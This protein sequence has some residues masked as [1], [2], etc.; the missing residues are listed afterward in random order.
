MKKNWFEK[1][2]LILGLSKSGIAAAKY[3][4]DKCANVYI[5]ESREERPEDKDLIEELKAL[6]IQVEMGGHSDEFIN[7]SKCTNYFRS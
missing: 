6:D 5:T 3:L 2:V 1:K 4:S 7:D